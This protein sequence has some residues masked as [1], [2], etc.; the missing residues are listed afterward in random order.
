MEEHARVFKHQGRSGDSPRRV[1]IALIALNF[2]LFLVKLVVGLRY[3]SLAILSDAGNSLTDIVTSGIILLAVMEAAK[4]A[5]VGHPFGHAR[6]EPL[7]A[8]TVAVL[9]CVLAVE[10]LREAVARLWEGAIP[11]TGLAPVLTLVAVIAVKGV[12]WAVAGPMGRRRN[13]AALTA[14]A[15]DAKMDVVISLLALVGVAGTEMGWTDLDGVASLFIA[16]WIGWVGLSLGRENGGKLLGQL[17]DATSVRLIRARLEV[18]KRQK[19][20]RNFHELRIHYVGAEIHLA[21]HVEVDKSLGITRAHELDEEIQALLGG[22]R[23]VRNVAVHV[24]PV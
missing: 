9:T 7:A 19:R 13:S 12:I 6:A 8:F 16:V 11:Q 22:V 24:D 4:P 15:I 23:G 17:P 20:I 18:L 14:A 10:V 2:L 1:V 21:V 3:D 5:D